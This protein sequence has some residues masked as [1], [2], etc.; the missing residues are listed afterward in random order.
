MVYK[1]DVHKAILAVELNPLPGKIDDL[2]AQLMTASGDTS[3]VTYSLA[4][5]YH[6]AKN[7]SRAKH[8]IEGTISQRTNDEAY[9]DAMWLQVRITCLHALDDECRLA[10]QRYLN[11]IPNGQG[12]GVADQI[13]KT[14]QNGE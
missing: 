2:N 5:Q 8:L 6:L 1:T 4:V 14:I 7:D 13:L 11:N 10:A 9:K 12:A 3:R